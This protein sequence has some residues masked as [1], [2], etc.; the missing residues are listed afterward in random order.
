MRRS[1]RSLTVSGTPIRAIA[2]LQSSPTPTSRR[3]SSTKN[4]LPSVRSRID[5]AT[6]RRGLAPCLRRDE[7]RDVVLPEPSDP[8][9]DQHARAAQLGERLRERV[10]LIHLGLPVG[11]QDQHPRSL[12]WNARR[13]AGAAASWRPPSEGHRA[14]GSAVARPRPQRNSDATA[15]NRQELLALGVLDARA[16][17]RLWR[18]RGELG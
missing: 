17:G 16:G 13:D 14:R 2:A 9:A 12:R 4:G 3:T 11:A 8:Q 7:P 1:R 10:G 15:S 18:L 6:P 5:R